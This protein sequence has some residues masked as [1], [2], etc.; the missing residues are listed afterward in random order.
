MA[1]GD[2]AAAAGLRVVPATED[3][4][5]GYDAI[6]QRGDELADHMTTGTHPVANIVGLTTAL[7][8]RLV[9]TQAEYSADFAH[10]DTGIATAAAAAAAAQATANGKRAQGDGDFGGTPIYSAHARNTPVTSGYV[11]AYLNSDGRLGSSPSSI[12]YKENVTA[13]GVALADILAIEPREFDRIGGA[14]EVGLIAEEVHEHVPQI[15]V[16]TGEQIDGVHYHLLAV[17]QQK[18]IRDHE[19]RLTEHAEQIA[20]L[21]ERLDALE[22]GN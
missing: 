21:I 4:R 16:W 19:A 9:K 11:A 1:T 2:K 5:L 10:R 7:D 6:N 18:V 20:T 8:A 14:H 17:L 15:V 12:R 22:E 13:L 3:R